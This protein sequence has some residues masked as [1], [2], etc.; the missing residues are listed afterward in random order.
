M[1]DMKGIH[2]SKIHQKNN[3]QNS[4]MSTVSCKKIFKLLVR[5][6]N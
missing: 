6:L 3:A 5:K 1:N 2:A 4:Q